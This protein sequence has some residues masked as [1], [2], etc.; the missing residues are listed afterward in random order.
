MSQSKPSTS[1]STSTST[2]K[3]KAKAELTKYRDGTSTKHAQELVAI[4]K[5]YTNKT[6]KELRDAYLALESKTPNG[7]ASKVVSVDT[8][9]E[10]Y[11]I[12]RRKMLVRI[13]DFHF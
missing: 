5:E 1:T 13:Y 6:T 9:V 2:S 7:D 3:P 10:E 4:F 8:F 11:C 12:L